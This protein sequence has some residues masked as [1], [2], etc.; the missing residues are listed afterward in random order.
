MSTTIGA[1]AVAARQRCP[2]RGVGGAP[3]LW[4]NVGQEHRAIFFLLSPCIIGRDHGYLIRLIRVC[5]ETIPSRAKL[6][7]RIHASENK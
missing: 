2:G 5:R 6:K 7:G 1:Q 3:T 4:P